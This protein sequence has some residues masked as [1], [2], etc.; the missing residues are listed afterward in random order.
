[1]LSPKAVAIR[2]TVDDGG[3]ALYVP[4][5]HITWLA[6]YMCIF[7]THKKAKS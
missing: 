7:F 1:M 3:I 4:W 2:K 5:S 6:Y